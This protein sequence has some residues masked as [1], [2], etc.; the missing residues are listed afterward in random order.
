MKEGLFIPAWVP[1]ITDHRGKIVTQRNRP[2]VPKEFPPSGWAFER[3]F[4]KSCQR[5]DFAARRS[6]PMPSTKFCSS[7][8]QRSSRLLLASAEGFWLI[9]AHLDAVC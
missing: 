4:G 3:E 9:R 5:K 8:L 1:E 6:S 2:G 7:Q